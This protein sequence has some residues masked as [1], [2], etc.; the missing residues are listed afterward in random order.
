MSAER[1]VLPGKATAQFDAPALT[2]RQTWSHGPGEVP[3]PFDV[4]QMDWPT[5]IVRGVTLVPSEKMPVRVHCV[6]PSRQGGGTGM[7]GVGAGGGGGGTGEFPFGA[8]TRPCASASVMV[9]ASFS[10]CRII[11]SLIQP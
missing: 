6:R 3:P 11:S 8:M 2:F 1:Q 5:G 7:V 4:V 9:Q 10:R